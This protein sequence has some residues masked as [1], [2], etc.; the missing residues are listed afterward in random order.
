MIELTNESINNLRRTNSIAD[1][2][3]L[4]A[5]H[6]YTG[7]IR[8]PNDSE[9]S[10]T[11][12]KRLM[13]MGAHVIACPHIGNVGQALLRGAGLLDLRYTTNR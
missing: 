8:N 12:I 13:R 6:D 5:G 2:A 9:T 10:V 1:Q 7:V 4:V 3:M 11:R